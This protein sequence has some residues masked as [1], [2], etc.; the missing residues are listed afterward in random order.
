MANVKS[1]LGKRLQLFASDTGLQSKGKPVYSGDEPTTEP[2]I[3]F[4][5]KEDESPLPDARDIVIQ[6][7]KACNGNARLFAMVVARLGGLTYQQVGE[8]W[9]ISRQAVYQYFRRL[10]GPVRI[11]VAKAP[12]S[13]EKWKEIWQR[14]P[15][16][17]KK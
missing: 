15:L 10:P 2:D 11:L 17:G 9:G 16:E 13:D 6:I 7:A 3:Y 14:L 12:F 1:T 8:R 5:E 4:D